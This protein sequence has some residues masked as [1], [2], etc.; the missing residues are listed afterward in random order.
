MKTVA[1]AGVFL[2][3][4]AIP[5]SAAADTLT[6]TGLGSGEWVSITAGGITETGWAG[7][8]DWWLKTSSNPAGSGFITYCADLYDDAKLPSQ[9]GVLETTSSLSGATSIHAVA[10]AGAMAA[11][12]VDTYSSGAHGSDAAAAGLQLAIWEA[13]YGA[14]AISYTAAGDV[15][16]AADNFYQG[17]TTAL[18][19]NPSAVLTSTALYFDVFNDSNHTGRLANG[20]DQIATP[21]PSTLWQ[22]GLGLT[23]LLAFR[24]RCR[25]NHGEP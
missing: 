17:L 21:E 8:I 13:L 12:L 3:L 19:V 4:A 25:S 11:Y 15:R 10:D 5:R 6:F 16:T 9:T 7:E 14:G 23:A 22:F 18:T 2:A 20:Q 24:R 1:L